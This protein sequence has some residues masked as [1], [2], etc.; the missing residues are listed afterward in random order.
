MIIPVIMDYWFPLL[1]I[2]K[3]EL[4]YGTKCFIFG[5]H[6][7]LV[8]KERERERDKN[9]VGVVFTY[10]GWKSISDLCFKFL[11]RSVYDNHMTVVCESCDNT[12]LLLIP[13]QRHIQT[14]DDIQAHNHQKKVL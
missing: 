1:Y 9:K 13:L 7:R 10:I 3:T 5:Y 2:R 6:A 4:V 12:Y 11:G 8:K 14:I